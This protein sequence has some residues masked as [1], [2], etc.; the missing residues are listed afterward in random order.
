MECVNHAKISKE[1]K[2]TELD[3]DQIN[4][5]QVWRLKWMEH[6]KSLIQSGSNSTNKNGSC[7][8]DQMKKETQDTDS[9]QMDQF[10]H[11]E[12]ESTPRVDGT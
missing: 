12:M 3:V 9:T 7:K 1:P 6:A 11:G 5:E 10:K 2:E 4:A 8:T